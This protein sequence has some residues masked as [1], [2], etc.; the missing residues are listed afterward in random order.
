MKKQAILDIALKIIGILMLKDALV[1]A[2]SAVSTLTI[3]FQ[4]PSNYP[5]S[6][7]A[8][9]QSTVLWTLIYILLGFLL[10]KYSKN[11]A[12]KLL[13]DG[14]DLDINLPDDWEKRMF[15]IAV[16]VVGVISLIHGIAGICPHF[17]DWSRGEFKFV[18]FYMP[19]FA[20]SLTQAVL[21][22]YLL[23]GGEFIFKIAYRKK[24]NG[25]EEEWEC[26]ECGA[27]VPIEAIVCP[28]CGADVSKID[29]ENS[30]KI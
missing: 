26:S 16:K 28:K 6:L 8:L 22:L 25:N 11:L 27:T 13:K 12:A 21:G 30:K 29:G 1:S 2:I 4:D 14:A 23:I 3:Y 15:S 17:W 20:T 24:Q 9:F 19:T 7:L 5:Y 10:L 18:S